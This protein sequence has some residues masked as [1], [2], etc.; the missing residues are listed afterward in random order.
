MSPQELEK[1]IQ[2]IWELFK[3]TDRRL[4]RR[5][6]ETDRRLDKRIEETDQRLDKRFAAT[7]QRMQITDRQIRELS[8]QIGGL[9][10]K[11]GS[12]A[13]GMAYPSMRRILFEHFKMDRIFPNAQVR[14]N[15]EELELGVLA[16]SDGAVNQV[17]V[18]EVKSRLR[19][20][21]L[22]EMQEN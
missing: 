22:D 20:A 19:E 8:K 12:F 10:N 13:E 17:F 15:G 18:V 21:D 16:F 6:E 7:D 11:F 1:S 14:Q 3:E 2:E 4:D 9:G 5:I